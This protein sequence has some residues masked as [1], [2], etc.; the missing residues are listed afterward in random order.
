MEHALVFAAIILGLASAT[1]I[2]ANTFGYQEVLGASFHH[3]YAP[4]K[5]LQWAWLYQSDYP[6]AIRKAASVG[7][8]IASSL[9]LAALLRRIVT[10][11]SSIAHE[12]IHGSARW[13]G[14]SDMVAA[15][16]LGNEGAYVG[17]WRDKN[18]VHYLRHNGP[19]HILCYAPTRSGKGVGLVIPTLLSWKHSAVI[20]D[21]KGELWELTAGW[22]KEHA[23]NKVLRFDPA[24]ATSCVGFN[25]LEEIRLGTGHE[26][27]DVQNLATLLVDPDGKGLIDH[28]QKTAQSLL[29][30]TML[31]LLYKSHHEGKI[32]TLPALDAM[33]SNPER[34]IEELWK[35][36][37]SY[38]HRGD[39]PQP[40]IA[41][42]SGSAAATPYR[43]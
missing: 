21:L 28:W 31:H 33:L 12:F 5:I 15:A 30:G 26:V 11:N 3:L 42:V 39:A 4:W 8:V 22:R 34:P 9:M 24:N 25:P 2:F 41:H 17:A 27:G 14:K 38:K 18:H 19:E 43:R 23:S 16:L 36:M 10:A 7:L 37:T 6:L 35:E 13:A 1:Q 20:L 40:C 29:V 32:A